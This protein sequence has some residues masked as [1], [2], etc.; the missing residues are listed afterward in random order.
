M[1]ARPQEVLA[2]GGRAWI[3]PSNK[4]P[5]GWLD[6]LPATTDCLRDYQRTLI[7]DIAAALDTGHARVLGQA[8]T[9]AG[10]TH[11]IAAIVMAAQLA[12]RRVLI[13]ATR[14]RLVRQIQCIT[15][16]VPIIEGA[17]QAQATRFAIPRPLW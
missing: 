17:I 6:K 5:D 15:D 7:A 1:S 10:K 3:P 8:P 11:V 2:L 16:V 9:G 13:L 12:D 4:M 14:T